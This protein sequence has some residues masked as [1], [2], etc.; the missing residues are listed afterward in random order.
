MP[1]N[2]AVHLAEYMGKCPEFLSIEDIFTITDN[3]KGFGVNLTLE[4]L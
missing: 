1:L 3:N 4:N 2:E